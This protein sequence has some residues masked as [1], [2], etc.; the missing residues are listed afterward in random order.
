MDDIVAA[1][2]RTAGVDLEGESR[3]KVDSKFR[4]PS[5]ATVACGAATVTWLSDEHSS[6][7]HRELVSLRAHVADRLLAAEL[8]DERLQVAGI[9]TSGLGNQCRL[10]VLPT[11]LEVESLPF[12]TDARTQRAY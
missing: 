7:T 4:P 11:G 9:S 3:A 5:F 10:V 6:H 12:L 1:A 2:L 8:P